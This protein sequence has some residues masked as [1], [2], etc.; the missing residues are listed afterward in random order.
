MGSP[1]PVAGR[2]LGI[3]ARLGRV[4]WGLDWGDGLQPALPRTAALDGNGQSEDCC[5]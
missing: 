4:W 2:R 5:S 1:V 3:A